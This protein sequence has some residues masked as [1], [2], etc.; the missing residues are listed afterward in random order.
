MSIRLV[1]SF[2]PENYPLTYPSGHDA[3]K[4]GPLDDEQQREITAAFRALATRARIL[5]Y[6]LL[7]SPQ[8][9]VLHLKTYSDYR[10][11][12]IADEPEDTVD[13]EFLQFPQTSSL[14]ALEHKR[15]SL[16]DYA[17]HIL[18]TKGAVT[19]N[20]I[21]DDRIIRIHA[22]SKESYYDF[23]DHADQNPIIQKLITSKD[24]APSLKMGA[25]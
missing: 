1:K 21:P 15:A 6:M 7:A 8:D 10:R 24:Y 17:T 25:A 12:S 5:D 2:S 11:L 3:K 14:A 23:C 22:I 13:H 9:V 16:E 4:N 19:F 18:G 20:I